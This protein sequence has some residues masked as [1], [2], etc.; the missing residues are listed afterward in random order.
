MFRKIYASA[1]S[2][3]LFLLISSLTLAQTGNVR[4]FV[5]DKSTGEPV[6][7]STVRLEKT[8]LG[9]LTDDNGYFHIA[10]VPDGTYNLSVTFMGYDTLTEKITIKNG[11]TLTKKFFISESSVLLNTVN[12]TAERTEARTETQTSIIKLT[13]KQIKQ[14][15][16][17][18]GQP[19]LAQYLQVLPGV[20]FTGDQG[21]QLY[22]R[23]GSPIQNKLLLDG[24]VI[25]NPFHSIGLFS[26]IETDI[27][28][29]ADIFTGGFGA[30][31]GGRISSMMDLTTRD[32]NKNRL[33]G[34]VGA[35]T[36]GAKILLEGPLKK[37]KENTDDWGSTFILS[38]KN[39]YLEQSSK[40]F[41]NYIDTNGLPFNFNDFYGKVS[42][43][44]Q[45]GSKVSLFGFNY[46][47][48]VD[49]YKSLSDFSWNSLGGGF[50][51]ILV[52]GSTAALIE[53]NFGYSSYDIKLSEANFTPKTSGINGFNGGM[54]FSYFFGKNTLKYGVELLGNH[55]EFFFRNPGS[56]AETRISQNTTEIAPYASFK[57]NANK[58]IIE[59]GFR[60][61]WYASLNE[62]SPEPRLS[63]KYLLT[64]NIRLK[65]AAGLYSQNLIAANSE[66]DIVNLFYGFLSGP[67]E[68]LKFNG[69]S[70]DS[71]LQKAQ[72]VIFGIE[73]DPLPYLVTNFEAYYKDFTQL[74]NVNRNKILPEDEE[75]I[76]ETG[77]AKGVDI[78]VKYDRNKL[79][80]WFAYSLTFV[81]R[82][83]GKTTYVTHFDRRHNMNLVTSYQ[84][85]KRNSWEA[86]LRW[87]FG[88][89]FPFTQTQ[90]VY[91]QLNFPN[92]MFDD[93]L[94]QNGQIGFIYGDYNKGRL[95]YYHRLDLGITK[96]FQLSE[97]SN[98]E[99]NFTT[100]NVYDRQNI[101]YVDR[102]TNG[103]T[104]QLPLM[105]SLG[106]TWSF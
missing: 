94:S 83:D 98:L 27:I 31:Y 30:E 24:M 23:G 69:K 18:G 105:P 45:N 16:S 102:Y 7:Y 81:D 49:N 22:I 41:Y 48:R 65:A 103:K 92:G 28:R 78:S 8:K 58:F 84:F 91:E 97:T 57:I 15:P 101:F 21:G 3:V 52:P 80:V 29:S 54:N 47:D 82:Y 56:G 67:D 95:S 43:N 63:A 12:V 2:F 73:Y 90:G 72:H 25:Y 17:V 59:P 5:Y 79:Y 40:I 77:S 51:I 70:V 53:I 19:D 61:Q 106:A 74:T 4:G 1:F 93:V 42:L 104:Y 32:G 64:D 76:V 26:V 100:T 38:Y 68:S 6:I 13:P 9:A 96:R 62:I 86:S 20:I 88:S 46:M 14:L 10:S 71:R 99:V 85:G 35:S 60:V 44:L 39:S 36:F 87:N 50:N 33:S 11:N 37:V 55:T 89:P 75:Y 66:Q 34:K